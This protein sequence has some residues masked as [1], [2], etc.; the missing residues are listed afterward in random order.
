MVPKRP[1]YLNLAQ[2]K[3]PLPAL[4][5]IL[6]RISG[7]LLFLFIPFLLYLLQQSLG[8]PEKF[9][10]LQSWLSHPLMKL[11]MLGLTWAFLHHFFAGLRFLLLDLHLGTE[12]R[13]ARLLSVAVLALSLAL[14]VIFAAVWLW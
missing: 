13:Q 14:T 2:I 8:S 12:L 5:S 7:M 11:V 3:L 9:T 10:A 6:H 4:V 1:V